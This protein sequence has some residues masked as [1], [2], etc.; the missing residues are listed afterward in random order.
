MAKGAK[1][2]VVQVIGTVVDVEFPG[3][4]LPPINNAVQIAV[5]GDKLLTEVQQ[6]LG[7]NWVR[8]L[9]MGPTDGLRR[10]AEALDLGGPIKVPVGPTTLGRLFNVLGV[11][12]DNLGE[13]QIEQ[14]WPIHRPPPPLQEQE[15]TPQVLETGLKVMDLICPFTRG[16][17]VGAYGGAGVGKTIIIM[18]LIRNIAR[19]HGG[20]SVFAGVGERSREGN[21]L[22]HEMKASGVIDKTV[23]V[24]GQMNEPPGVRAR[25]GL[26]GVT[27][28]EYFRDVAG[29]DVLLFIDN[30]YRYILA[31]MEVSALLGR[32]PSAVGYQ[33]TLATD[34]GA[35]EERITSTKKGSIT[36]FQAIYVPADDYTD[37]GIVTTF[38]HLDAVV[39]LDRAIVEQGIYPAVDPLTST[40]RI[41]DPRIVG[42]E[43]Y[44]T[45]RGV[46]AVLQR[47]RDLQDII[48]ILGIEEL[49]EEDKLTVMRARKIQ[50]F[51]SQ[52]MFV[53]EAF[54]ARPGKYVPIRETVRG[55]KEILEGKWDHLPEQA[56]YMVG[57]IEEAAEEAE[58]MEKEAAGA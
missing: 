14:E 13:V 9:A 32:M 53:A 2:K 57:G 49:S 21:D 5:D 7:N 48:A 4:E 29:Q 18:E 36:S 39:A 37:P 20:T 46:Q 17:K 58:R 38:G 40:S 19:E 44:Q 52:P 30:V 6:H 33:P 45:A 28:A 47:Y 54:T 8:C 35:L 3:E 43:H 12:I 24:F 56:F 23:L 22:W 26:T 55:F 41:L 11:P 50:R 10:G 25:V 15:T 42:E 27:M 51:L 34:I 1:G 16:G 31:N